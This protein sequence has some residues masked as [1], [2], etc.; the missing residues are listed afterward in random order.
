MSDVLEQRSG[1]P[2]HLRVLAAKYSRKDWE[3]HSNFDEMTRFW[4]DRHLM[5]RDLI[6]RLQTQSE[7]FLDRPYDR[8]GSETAR[9]TG[10]F[11]NQLHGHHTIEDQHYFPQFNRLDGRL[12]QA[13][14]LLDRDHHALD[15]HIHALAEKT[16]AVLS[17]L[18]SE[19]DAR[20]QTD[21]LL[22]AQSDFDRFLQ[23]HLFDEEEIIV[24]LVLEYAPD[25][26][27]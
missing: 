7:N 8:F 14:E 4:L 13:F 26:A 22:A 25:F 20:A 19:L 5:F 18:Q 11:L 3:G 24:P 23:R 17:A 1:L 10:F 12:D 16:N 9:Y 2:E 6:G 27:I 15:G 21:L